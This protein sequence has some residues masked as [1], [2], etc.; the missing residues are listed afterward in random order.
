[1]FRSLGCKVEP[2]T[3]EAR[4]TVRDKKEKE[5]VIKKAI[6][7]VPLEFPKVSRGRK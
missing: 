2:A 1:M 4:E 6:L 7:K 3:G 5:K